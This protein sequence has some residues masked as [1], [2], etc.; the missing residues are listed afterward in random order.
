M[1]RSTGRVIIT[2]DRDFAEYFHRVTQPQ[3]GIIYLNL[4]NRQRYISEINQVLARFFTQHAST[5]ELEHALVIV[6]GE[7]VRII[8]PRRGDDTP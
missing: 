5:I 7:T 3:I 6:T 2:L 4:P 8:G 1:A